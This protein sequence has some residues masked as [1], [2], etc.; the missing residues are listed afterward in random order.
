MSCSKL[1]FSTKRL[2]SCFHS[3]HFYKCI[4]MKHRHHVD[5]SNPTKESCIYTYLPIAKSSNKKNLA[6]PCFCIFDEIERV[7]KNCVHLITHGG[8]PGEGSWGHSIFQAAP[9]VHKIFAVVYAPKE[10]VELPSCV[11]CRV[12]SEMCVFVVCT[13]EVA[14]CTQKVPSY[15][16]KSRE[17]S[18]IQMKTT[19]KIR[20]MHP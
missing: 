5:W 1:S 16:S 11:F 3:H 7:G 15:V 19:K 12:A 13:S 14:F 10:W 17:K 20:Q 8:Q 9:H 18:P 4:K 2:A 6:P